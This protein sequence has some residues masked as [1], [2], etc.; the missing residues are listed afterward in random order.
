MQDL[1]FQ[2]IPCGPDSLEARLTALRWE[3]RY[4][5]SRLGTQRRGYPN[6]TI[7]W[8]FERL[9]ETEDWR[10]REA[11]T[12]QEW[13]RGW[14]FIKEFFG[15]VPPRKVTFQLV[16]KWYYRILREHGKDAAWRAMKIWRSLWGYMAVMHLCDA[17]K[18]PSLKIRRR[19]QNSRTEYW[20]DGEIDQLIEG[21]IRLNMFAI[22]CI[23]S[24]AWDTIFQPGDTR[25]LKR[26]E[27]FIV[28]GDWVIDRGRV[29]NGT[30]I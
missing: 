28:G 16:D 21:A 15:D 5:D 12:R 13:E 29:K 25:T 11:G 30:K 23:I 26:R 22:A 1:G 17:A 8:A 19:Q 2:C 20:T 9:R 18:D 27:L 10:D 24:I 3:K 6:G 7:G 14:S 4:Q